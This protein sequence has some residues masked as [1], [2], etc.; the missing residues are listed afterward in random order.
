MWLYSYNNYNTTTTTTTTNNNDNNNINNTF[1]LL[2]LSIKP[3]DN[4]QDYWELC[5]QWGGSWSGYAALLGASEV[6]VGWV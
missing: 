2:A 3:K 4:L 1:Y 5:N 6:V